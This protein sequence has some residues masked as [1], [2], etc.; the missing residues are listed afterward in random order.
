MKKA[1][2]AQAFRKI[3]EKYMYLALNTREYT[4]H[5]EK[6]EPNGYTIQYS[7]AVQE[8]IE[9]GNILEQ[10]QYWGEKVQYTIII[11]THH[12]R[13]ESKAES[14][15]KSQVNKRVDCSLGQIMARSRRK[16]KQT[17]K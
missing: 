5:T 14:F 12:K 16:K 10:R 6:S 15:F 4:V 1:L 13:S 2:Q 3:T 11:I 9:F 7:H 17:K 8:S